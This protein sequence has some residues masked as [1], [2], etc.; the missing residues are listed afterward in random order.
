MITNPNWPKIKDALLKDATAEG[1]G[2]EASD[3]PD[4]VACVFVQKMQSLLKYTYQ[5][6]VVWQGG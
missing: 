1:K 4:I 2:Q 6:W 5:E 3:R